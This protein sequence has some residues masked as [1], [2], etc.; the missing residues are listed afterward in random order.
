MAGTIS[1]DNLVSVSELSHG[2][3]S[4]TLGRVSD[5]NPVV[6]MRNNKPAAV[7]ITPDDYKRYTEA[8]ENFALYL[9]AVDRMKHDDGERRT[10]TDV[11]GEDYRPVDDGFEPE[12]E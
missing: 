3:V 5:D 2:G 7:V 11:F 1:L 8:E 9:E 12:F 4:R 6:V 10:M